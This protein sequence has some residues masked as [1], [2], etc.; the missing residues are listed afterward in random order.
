MENIRVAYK[1]LAKTPPE[2]GK[3]GIYYTPPAKEEDLLDVW[4]SPY[5]YSLK[6]GGKG[7]TLGTLGAD[8]AAGGE[9]PDQDFTVTK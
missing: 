7:Y 6:A 5:T 2:A 3:K 1:Y 4:Q 8:G 9:G